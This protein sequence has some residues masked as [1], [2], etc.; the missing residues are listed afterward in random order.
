MTS[1]TAKRLHSGKLFFNEERGGLTRKT[2]ST[3]FTYVL[4]L[5]GQ[6]LSGRQ[7]SMDIQT[8]LVYQSSQQLEIHHLFRIDVTLKDA[9]PRSVNVIMFHVGR[10]D[11]CAD[12]RTHV[13][14]VLF[15]HGQTKMVIK[16]RDVK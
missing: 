6:G 10:R 9:L 11:H 7:I 5:C 13:R 14:T 15:G 3:T 2:I 1:R 8:Q 12:V 16:M 4:S